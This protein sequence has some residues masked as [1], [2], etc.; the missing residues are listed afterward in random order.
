MQGVQ[1]RMEELGGEIERGGHRGRVAKERYDALKASLDRLQGTYKVRIEIEEIF[2][3]GHLG[4]IKSSGYGRNENGLS[5]YGCGGHL[6]RK[7]R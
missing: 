4:Q 3:G 2:N 5:L 1:G 7:N 6:R